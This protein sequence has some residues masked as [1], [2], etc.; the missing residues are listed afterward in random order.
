MRAGLAR[1]LIPR[2]GWLNDVHALMVG[3]STASVCSTASVRSTV[4]TPGGSW[5]GGSMDALAGLQEDGPKG[6]GRRPVGLSSGRHT[7]PSGGS[8]NLNKYHTDYTTATTNG[9][10]LLPTLAQ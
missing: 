1:H 4:S 9:P 5:M 10:R 7:H 2:A 6:I 8:P 3:G